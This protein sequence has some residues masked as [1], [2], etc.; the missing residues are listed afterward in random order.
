M[1]QILNIVTNA[2]KYNIMNIRKVLKIC[3]FIGKVD[4]VPVILGSQHRPICA[5]HNRSIVGLF[6][7]KC[8]KELVEYSCPYVGT[9]CC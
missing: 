5:V 9:R 8:T 3:S 6:S 4:Y 1:F 7:V 2:I